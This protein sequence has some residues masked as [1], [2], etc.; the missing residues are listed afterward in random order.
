MFFGVEP[1]TRFVHTALQNYIIFIAK[2][3]LYGPASLAAQI[4]DHRQSDEDGHAIPIH[5][6]LV[7]ISEV[8]SR[9]VSLPENYMNMGDGRGSCPRPFTM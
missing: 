3:L 5:I 8:S 1:F 2:L 6:K 7:E 4:G 9:L